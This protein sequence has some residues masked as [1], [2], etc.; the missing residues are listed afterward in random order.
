MEEQESSHTVKP[1]LS[2]GS[3]LRV[4]KTPLVH[5]LRTC[6]QLCRKLKH[7]QINYSQLVIQLPPHQPTVTSFVIRS[8]IPLPFSQSFRP[9]FYRCFTLEEAE[10]AGPWCTAVLR[11]LG[12]EPSSPGSQVSLLFILQRC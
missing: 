10:A 1:L 8:S 3:A 11:D 2:T 4:N 7:I 6:N 12:T 9:L 5:F